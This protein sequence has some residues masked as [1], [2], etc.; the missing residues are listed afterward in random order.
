MIVLHSPPARIDAPVVHISDHVAQTAGEL[1]QGAIEQTVRRHGRCRLGLSGGSTPGPIYAWLAANL[2]HGLYRQ[3]RVTWCDERVLPSSATV[4]GD[5]QGFDLQSNLYLAFAE[6]LGRV[7]F[8]PHQALPLALSTD[9]K[10]EVLRF[11]H[12]FQNEFAGGLDVAL[13]GVGPDG[14]VASLFA[15]HPGLQVD[16]ICLAIHDSPKPPAER[17]S[18]G[19]PVLNRT[20]VVVV[21][22]QGAAKADMLADA[23]FGTNGGAGLPVA[24]VHGGGDLHWVL[25]RAAARCL[26]DRIWNN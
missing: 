7:P 17:I 9:A 23:Y 6:W 26:V 20:R 3:L 12:A 21:A 13:L 4:P 5:W 11:G 14:H 18:L 2:P 19:L 1:L 16:D 24:Q 10:A 25:D 15:G 8:D 22:A